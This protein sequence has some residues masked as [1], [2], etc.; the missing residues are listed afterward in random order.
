MGRRN[1]I[2]IEDFS[3]LSAVLLLSR[4][5][6]YRTLW[7]KTLPSLS[8]WHPR[9][10]AQ[11]DQLRFSEAVKPHGQ[12]HAFD[13]LELVLELGISV[14]LPAALLR[15]SF[16]PL[17]V[18]LHGRVTGARASL[19][20]RHQHMCIIARENTRFGSHEFLMDAE[21]P[22]CTNRE[23]CLMTQVAVLRQLQRRG[24]RSSFNP[25]QKIKWPSLSVAFCSG[26]L[27]AFAEKHN[28][29][30]AALWDRLPLLFGLKSWEVLGAM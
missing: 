9:T 5:Y 1:E 30:R 2:L 27:E 3:E 28:A 6:D 12:W 14:M 26:C 8:Y 24:S 20:V 18:L 7:A 10:L 19:D 25:L 22:T 13:L 21:Q 16:L 15:V 4:K 17:E 29:A 11:W 23:A